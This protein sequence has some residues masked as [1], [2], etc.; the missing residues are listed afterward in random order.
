MLEVEDPFRDGCREHSSS[1]KI[2]CFENAY[3][4]SCRSSSEKFSEGSENIPDRQ[5]FGLEVYEEKL[6]KNSCNI[7]LVYGRD[8][9]A[10]FRKLEEKEILDSQNSFLICVGLICHCDCFVLFYCKIDD[11]ISN[12]NKRTGL[13]LTDLLFVDQYKSILSCGSISQC[14]GDVMF[15][16]AR[17][18]DI[19]KNLHSSEF[20]PGCYFQSCWQFL[21][22]V[23]YR[24]VFPP[25]LRFISRA[26]TDISGI[27]N[28]D[29][30][31]PLLSNE[32]VLLLLGE[33]TQGYLQCDEWAE[34][35]L[36]LRAVYATLNLFLT[37]LREIVFRPCGSS[38]L[39]C[40]G[41]LTAVSTHR[42]CLIWRHKND[43]HEYINP[44]GMKLFS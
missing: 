29:S 1:D 20:I 12:S 17:T 26:T 22:V 15:K 5:S 7:F 27:T 38:F 8:Q 16:V 28:L 21:R 2:S 31:L 41:P 32:L 18:I 36:K 4:Y 3:V 19:A 30:K 44:N 24:T 23:K 14:D 40:S 10:V 34:A 9:F 25:N 11:H 35:D 33:A 37:K 39:T 42:A 13:L 6:L 43:T